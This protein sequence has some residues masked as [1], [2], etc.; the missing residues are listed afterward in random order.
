MQGVI[1]SPP[2]FDA[3][4]DCGIESCCA[5]GYSGWLGDGL[6]TVGQIDEFFTR[7]CEG[8]D[9]LIRQPAACRHFLNWFD[10]TPR[11]QMRRELLTEVEL[12]LQQRERGA[13]A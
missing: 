13:A 6:N 1:S 5:I 7:I 9:A 10:N 12:A 8:A 11:S 2:A 4:D 3:Q